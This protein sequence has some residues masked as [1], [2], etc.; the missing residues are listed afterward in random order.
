M[1]PPVARHAALRLGFG[2]MLLACAWLLLA[3]MPVLA[4]GGPHV[5]S[6][7]SGASGLTAD[8]CAECHRAHTAE[9]K[10]I[11]TGAATVF[12]P[13]L[14]G[15]ATPE[16]AVCLNC[17]GAAG[18]G[19]TTDVEDGVQYAIG[20]A[21]LRSTTLAGALRGGGFVNA[22]I[23]SAHSSRKSY[24]VFAGAEL[25]TSFSSKVGVLATGEAV[26]SAH[27][28]LDGTGGVA[29]HSR[30]WGNGAINSGAGA[31]VELGCTACHNPHGNG[32]YRILIPIPAPDGSGFVAATSTVSVTD[33]PALNWAATPA[34]T[35]NYTVQWGRTLGDVTSGTYVNNGAAGTPDP[36]AGDYWRKYVPWDIVPVLPALPARQIPGLPAG[37]HAGD[38]PMFVPGALDNLTS[39]RLQISAWCATC[40]SRYLAGGNPPTSSGDATYNYRHQTDSTECT[41]CHVA[42]GTDAA[43]TGEFSGP[44]TYPDGSAAASVTTGTGPTAT[45]TYSNSRLLKID[46]R[47]TCQAC[48]DPTKTIPYD[49][50]VIIH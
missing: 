28:D 25:A 50:S 33:G 44:M 26:T 8:T 18:T 17:H 47:G 12:G 39:F 48:H 31:V 19:A 30:A 11:T 37:G 32:Q 4:D 46:N 49:G 35:R 1:V 27:I 22:R 45:T 34:T 40:H 13:Q 29:S 2:A 36:T 10:F 43:M 16:D 9:G 23:D 5:Q 7:N 14:V 42:H 21:A 15:G 24:P 3:A 38:V 20:V 6:T 41:Q